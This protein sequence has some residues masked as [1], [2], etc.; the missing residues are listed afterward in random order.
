MST[1]ADVSSAHKSTP[2][3]SNARRRHSRPRDR[4]RRHGRSRPGPADVDFVVFRENT[5]GLYVNVGGRF[6][7]DT[8]DEIAVQEE[9]NT[10]KGVHRIV[11]HAFDF[12]TASG[13]TNVCMADKSNAMTQGHALWQRVF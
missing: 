2:R 1:S 11:R 8:D 9:I 3:T 10:Y 4:D 5:E 6:K 12:A 7:A 13:L